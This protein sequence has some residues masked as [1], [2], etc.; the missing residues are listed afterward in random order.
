MRTVAETHSLDD[1][2]GEAMHKHY[3]RVM[4]TCAHRV[5]MRQPVNYDHPSYS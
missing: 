3:F 1:S 5:L 4:H 2:I